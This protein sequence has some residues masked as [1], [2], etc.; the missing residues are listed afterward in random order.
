MVLCSNRVTRDGA[1]CLSEVLKHNAVLEIL[2]LSSNRIEDEGAVWLSQ[3]V[4]RPN[5]GLRA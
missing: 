4:S 1:R 3:A 5:C 2:D